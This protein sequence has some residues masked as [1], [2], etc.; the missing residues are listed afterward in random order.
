MDQ[1]LERRVQTERIAFVAG[2]L[3]DDHHS[4]VRLLTDLIKEMPDTGLNVILLDEVTYINNWDK[5]IMY[6][7]DS[8][9]LERCV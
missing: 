6:L 1:L 4:L 3:I 9:G 2:E 5:G 8:G 7:V